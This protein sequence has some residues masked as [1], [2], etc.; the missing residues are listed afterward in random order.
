MV[1]TIIFYAQ[2]HSS[3]SSSQTCLAAPEH[4]TPVFYF[5]NGWSWPVK[6]FPEKTA[7]L[8][9]SGLGWEAE[10]RANAPLP[11]CVDMRHL[12][13]IIWRT[14]LMRFG[15]DLARQVEHFTNLLGLVHISIWIRAH[16]KRLER[17]G[18]SLKVIRR[19]FCPSNSKQ[20]NCFIAS[21]AV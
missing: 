3:S 15:L 4:F 13:R 8:Y 7:V 5:Q 17:V 18:K 9:I 21:L 12:M 1:T 19:T 6:F 10:F 11:A 2:T 14:M 16:E 20:T